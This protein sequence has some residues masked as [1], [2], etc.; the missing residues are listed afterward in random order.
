[1]ADVPMNVGDVIYASGDGHV[2]L[3]QASP[4][5]DD[6]DDKAFAIGMV[7]AVNGEAVSYRTTGV[8]DNPAWSLTP[9]AVYY[10]SPTVPG[11]LTTEYT[12]ASGEFA[13]IVGTAT[14]PTQI[15][16]NIHWMLE[17]E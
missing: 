13:I 7:T 4:A 15:A 3:A 17:N 5:V 14:S 2:D 8:V 11:G 1:M 10:L 16:L 9:R 6:S 12:E